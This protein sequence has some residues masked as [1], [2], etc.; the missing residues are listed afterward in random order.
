MVTWSAREEIS[1][2]GMG[3]DMDRDYSETSDDFHDL[4]SVERN[5]MLFS[6]SPV[7]GEIP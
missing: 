2:L 7:W 1:M 4:E 5:M 6:P 3:W